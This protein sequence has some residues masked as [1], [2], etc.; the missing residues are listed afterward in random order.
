MVNRAQLGERFRQIDWLQPSA[1]SLLLANLVPIAALFIFHWDVFSLL[2][3][4]WLENVI[5]GLLN[6]VKMLLA[7]V[8][9]RD[10]PRYGGVIFGVMKFFMIP[11]F[12]IHYGMFTFAHGMFV[13]AIFGKTALHG[14]SGFSLPLVA[15]IIQDNHLEWPLAALVVSNLIGFG[16][17]YLWKGEFRRTNP[18]E[19]MT[20]PYRRVMVM[21]ITVIVG[22]MLTMALHAPEAALILLVG[23]K[24]IT[25]LWGHQKEREKLAANNVSSTATP[26]SPSIGSAPSVQNALRVALQARAAQGERGDLKKLVPVIAIVVVMFGG[27]L[28]FAGY[29]VY[30]MISS[31]A[32]HSHPASQ[33]APRVSITPL[34]D[35]GTGWTLDATRKMI[36]QTPAAGNFRGSAFSVNRGTLAG[37]VLTL[38]DTSGD[39]NRAIVIHFTPEQINA[40]ANR[41]FQFRTNDIGDFPEVQLV[42]HVK[43]SKGTDIRTFHG[44]YALQWNFGVKSRNHVPL[45]IYLCLPDAEKSFVAGTFNVVMRKDKSSTNSTA[46]N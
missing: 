2:F 46:S 19:L 17:D 10:M 9:A 11:F 43:N 18:A 25:D 36:P 12:C 20:A 27:G 29:V 26:S 34:Q 31:F 14:F 28:C 1:I 15:Q 4:F 44:G 24:T 37:Q 21:H 41:L 23:L 30:Q 3:L 22:A 40:M 16:W 38:S 45:R 6:V 35:T 32:T 8:G 7:G 42:T 13:V 39:T 33:A 5:I